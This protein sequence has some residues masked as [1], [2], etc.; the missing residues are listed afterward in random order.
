MGVG[1][2]ES[3][4]GSSWSVVASG[5]YRAYTA[6]LIR[7]CPGKTSLELFKPMRSCLQD[8]FDSIGNP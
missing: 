1:S 3:F 6:L 8:S 2:I 4:D 7:D 5:V